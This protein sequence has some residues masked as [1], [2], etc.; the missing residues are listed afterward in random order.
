MGHTPHE[1]IGGVLISLSRSRACRWI[2]HLSWWCMASATPDLRLPSQP[3]GITA[4][5]PV[6]NYTAWWQ[7]HMCEQLAQGYYLKTWGQELNLRPLVS[8]TNTLT[9]VPPGHTIYY[10]YLALKD[11]KTVLTAVE[12]CTVLSVHKAVCHSG[13]CDK[14]NFPCVHFLSG[15]FVQLVT[16]N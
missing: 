12:V 9:I 11:W 8:E 2:N 1:S 5:W 10:Y 13:C 15:I 14:H 16:C 6:P 3:Q 4:P 7:R